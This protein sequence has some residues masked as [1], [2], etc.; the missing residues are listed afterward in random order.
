[1]VGA[2]W[3]DGSLMADGIPTSVKWMAFL[4]L[5]IGS[6]VTVFAFFLGGAYVGIGVLLAILLYYVVLY[7]VGVRK[8][9]GGGGGSSGDGKV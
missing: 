3:Y 6:P 7:I 4:P 2:I 8:Y 5:V 1:M 9:I